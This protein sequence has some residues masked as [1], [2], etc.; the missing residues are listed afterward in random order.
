[1]VLIKN[2][3]SIDCK[4]T[5]ILK[6]EPLVMNISRMSYCINSFC[7]MYSLCVISKLITCINSHACVHE[8]TACFMFIPYDSVM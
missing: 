5:V 8:F 4:C 7:V 3:G 2:R 1:M 6:A